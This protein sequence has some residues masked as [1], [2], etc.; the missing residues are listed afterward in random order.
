MNESWK[1]RPGHVVA[2]IY[3]NH[4]RALKVRRFYLGINTIE[5][6]TIKHKMS[7]VL[8]VS[9]LPSF[10]SDSGLDLDVLLI[11]AL[12]PPLTLL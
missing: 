1:G 9:T 5:Q 2:I 12:R 6:K 10:F 8:F 11:F 4:G 7:V 3:H